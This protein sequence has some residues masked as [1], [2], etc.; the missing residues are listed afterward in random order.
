MLVLLA[1][2][3]ELLLAADST[4]NLVNDSITQTA[5]S[6]SDISGSIKLSPVEVKAQKYNA[7]Q[8]SSSQIVEQDIAKLRSTT[9]DTT[10]LLENIAG[11]SVYGA[12]AISA[13]PVIHGLADDRLRVQVDGMDVMS[14]CP[15]HMNSV[16]SFINPSKV[17]SI[18]AFAGI[19]AVSVGGDS[20]GGTIQVK[21]APPN[22]AN[23]DE[24]L[25]TKGSVSTFY[26]SNS[27]AHGYNLGAEVATQ[28]VSLSYSESRVDADNYTSS[29]DFKSPKL[30]SGPQK[31]G[32]ERTSANEVGSSSLRGSLNQEV[33]IAFRH[34]SHLLQLNV[35]QQSVD[36]EGFPNQRMDMTYN[37]NSLFNLRYTGQFDWGDLEARLYEQYI[38]HK[39]EMSLERVSALPAMPMDSQAQTKG[40]QIKATIIMSERDTVRVGAEFQNYKLNDWW[41]PLEASGPGSMCCDNFWNIRGGQ[42]DRVGIFGE[43]EANWNQQWLS[44]L[45]VR[46]D[47]VTSNAGLAQGYSSLF[48]YTRDVN[49]FNAQDHARTDHNIDWTALTRYTP[50]ATQSY[51]LGIAQKTRS[52]N[53]YER[54]PWST[55]SMAILMNNFV[56]DG[57][58]YVGNLDLK[59]EVA[60]TFSASADWHDAEKQKWGIKTTGYLTYVDSFID[61]KRCDFGNCSV[62]NL[63]KTNAYVLLQYENQSAK[64]YGLDISAYRH[65]GSLNGLGGFTASAIVNYVRGENQTT[66]DNLYHIMPL[67]AKVSLV[68]QLGTWANTAELQMVDA[69]TRVSHVRNE[70]PTEGYALLNLRSSYSFKHAR[71]DLSVEN[72]LNK[73]YHLPLGGAY[74]GQG[75]S[76]TS[77][78]IPWGATVPGMGR[79]VNVTLTLD[80]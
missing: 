17:G 74:L 16:L 33:G 39:M 71:L 80:F 31:N 1:M 53:L 13:L 4:L 47:T 43:W 64:L 3:S 30:W 11:V 18:T 62:A 32:L 70:V 52:P 8:I 35:S 57:N 6:N 73:Y 72:L 78:T 9:S 37:K 25:L 50:D 56:G 63:T 61:A 14:A 22:F 34:E 24:K 2:R 48:T 79:S 19:T 60:H 58:G 26:R 5:Q 46:S 20:I 44:L 27:H 15:N 49:N 21:S 55:N 10:R 7:S 42:R 38:R 41:S 67:N 66:G 29:K 51:E 40:G 45:G 54:Y 12:G 59:P 75:N 23:S 68:H 76:M 77:S 69:K 65:L 36:F 28:N